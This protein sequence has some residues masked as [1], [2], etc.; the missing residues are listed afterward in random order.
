MSNSI[1]QNKV[2]HLCITIL[3]DVDTLTSILENTDV[4]LHS[5]L[6]DELK[7]AG[8]NYRNRLEAMYEYSKRFRFNKLPL[9]Q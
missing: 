1:E 4:T 6:A 9:D 5:D 2:R 8:E 7:G 3:T